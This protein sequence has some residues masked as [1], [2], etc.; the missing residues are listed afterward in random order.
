MRHVC[1]NLGYQLVWFSTYVDNNFY[2]VTYAKWLQKCPF[3]KLY[4]S[5]RYMIAKMLI[6]MAYKP[7]RK[8][9]IQR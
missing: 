6:K 3:S 7:G 9:R 5:I 2:S 8:L 4:I 1:D